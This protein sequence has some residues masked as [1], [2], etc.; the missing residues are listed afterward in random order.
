MHRM[1]REVASIDLVCKVKL[2]YL[3]FVMGHG[4]Q[5]HS[6]AFVSLEMTAV[7][8]NK[9]LFA[10]LLCV[11]CLFSWLYVNIRSGNILLLLLLGIHALPLLV[12]FRLPI[13]T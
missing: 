13:K 11:C 10:S 9:T 2:S 4:T 1:Y 8:K 3:V 12:E 7:R 6:L 5:F